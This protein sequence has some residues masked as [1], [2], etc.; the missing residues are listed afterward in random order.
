[1]IPADS[2]QFLCAQAAV[3]YDH[4]TVTEQ[5]LFLEAVMTVGPAREA[6][7]AARTLHALDEAAARQGELFEVFAATRIPQR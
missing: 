7:L 2:I 6:E 1:M 3:R 5:R 4:M